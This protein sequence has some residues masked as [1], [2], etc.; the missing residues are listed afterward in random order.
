MQ[1]EAGYFRHFLRRGVAG[2]CATRR[3]LGTDSDGV[4]DRTAWTPQARH[5]GPVSCWTGSTRKRAHTHEQRDSVLLIEFACVEFQHRECCFE[6]KYC[7]R[8]MELLSTA[9]EASVCRAS[10]AHV[11][12]HILLLFFGMSSASCPPSSYAKYWTAVVCYFFI[13]S[14]FS[15]GECAGWFRVYEGSGRDEAVSR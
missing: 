7:A 4:S 3:G 1:A 14:L 8:V 6:Q 5:A 10:V 2:L 9:C 12:S 11:D 13:C 15:L